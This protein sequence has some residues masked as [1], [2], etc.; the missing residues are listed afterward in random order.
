M[1]NLC[2]YLFLR[3]S[4]CVT[5]QFEFVRMRPTNV[6]KERWTMKAEKNME[7]WLKINTLRGMM[8]C[9]RQT[10]SESYKNEY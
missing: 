9:I 7:V 2:R 1:L 4:G 10:W 3:L 6:H 5:R 8:K